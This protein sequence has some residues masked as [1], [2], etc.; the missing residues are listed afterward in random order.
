MFV[1]GKSWKFE[2]S[3]TDAVGFTLFVLGK[4]SKFEVATADA[5]RFIEHFV[6]YW[7]NPGSLKWPNYLPG[8]LPQNVVLCNPYSSLAEVILWLLLFLALE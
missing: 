8:C 2:V 7:V 1:L 4:S 5:V 3:T 6:S